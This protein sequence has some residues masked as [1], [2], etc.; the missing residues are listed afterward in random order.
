MQGQQG[1]V[2]TT[3]SKESNEGQIKDK[4]PLLAELLAALLALYGSIVFIDLPTYLHNIVLVALS[5]FSGPLFF[6][7]F[8][9][10]QSFALGNVYRH[11]PVT[12]FVF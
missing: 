7:S 6:V 5:T 8:F 3:L 9:P 11:W 2:Y 4:S 1:A 10:A 12:S